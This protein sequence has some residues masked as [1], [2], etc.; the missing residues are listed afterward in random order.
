[1]FKLLAFIFVLSGNS[2]VGHATEFYSNHKPNENLCDI[3]AVDFDFPSGVNPGL[4]AACE[5][6]TILCAS[7]A[8]SICVLNIF[9]LEKN[10]RC[11]VSVQKDHQNLLGCN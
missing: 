6:S 1:M 4:K 9:H 11:E 2:I 8:S 7:E 10:L 5:R 3:I